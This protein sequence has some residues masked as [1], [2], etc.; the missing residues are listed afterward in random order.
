MFV[1]EQVKFVAVKLV[2]GTQ[3]ASRFGRVANG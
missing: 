3:F 2:F 1:E